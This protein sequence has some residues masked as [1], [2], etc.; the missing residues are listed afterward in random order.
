MTDVRIWPPAVLREHA[1]RKA[2]LDARAA[3]AAGEKRLSGERLEQIRRDVIDP[4]HAAG[5]RNRFADMIRNS[6]LE[7]YERK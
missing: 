1:Q 4:L 3:D 6:L 7:G 5:K 2:A